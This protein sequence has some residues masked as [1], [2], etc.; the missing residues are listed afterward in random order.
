MR[1]LLRIRD[2]LRQKRIISFKSSGRACRRCE[3]PRLLK[4]KATSSKSR[5]PIPHPAARPLQAGDGR[6]G[7]I[8]VKARL[9]KPQ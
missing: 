7:L 6:A 3:R 8:N 1:Q 9:R 5:V 4:I 2:G